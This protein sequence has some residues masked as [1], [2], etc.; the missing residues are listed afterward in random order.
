VASAATEESPKEL[1][2]QADLTVPGPAG[3]VALLNALAS[4]LE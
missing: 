2:A 4:A 1:L 3:V